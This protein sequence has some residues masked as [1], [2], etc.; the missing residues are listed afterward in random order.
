MSLKVKTI[1]NIK[2]NGAPIVTGTNFKQK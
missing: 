2:G 1:L